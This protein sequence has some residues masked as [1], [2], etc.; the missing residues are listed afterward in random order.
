[1]TAFLNEAFWWIGV[2]VVCVSATCGLLSGVVAAQDS[3]IRNLKFQT[4]LFRWYAAE[5]RK[6]KGDKP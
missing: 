2:V 6:G 1:M 3:I 5:L 4:I